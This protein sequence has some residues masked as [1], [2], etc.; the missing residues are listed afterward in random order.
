MDWLLHNAI[1]DMP[2]PW[3]L[4][5]YGSFIVITWAACFWVARRADH[6]LELPPP[7]RRGPL[8]VRH[9]QQET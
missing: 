1:A 4:L 2:G 5:Y 3:F 8:S 6:T 9:Q 7:D